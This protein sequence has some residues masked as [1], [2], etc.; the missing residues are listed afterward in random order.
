VIR[1]VSFRWIFHRSGRNRTHRAIA[2]H[3]RNVWF[4]TLIHESKNFPAGAECEEDLG[5]CLGGLC[6]SAWECPFTALVNIDRAQRFPRSLNKRF[7]EAYNWSFE[8]F[9]Y[10]LDTSS[11][12]FV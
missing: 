3:L 12:A 1:R 9:V 7:P 2:V 11:N 4:E 10:P 6:A 8:D 5:C